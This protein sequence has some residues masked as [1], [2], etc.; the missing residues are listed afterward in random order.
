[1]H[2]T[3]TGKMPV[4]STRYSD[5]CLYCSFFTS[6]SVGNCAARIGVPTPR[7][8]TAF[9]GRSKPVQTIHFRRY[10]Q[11]EGEEHLGVPEEDV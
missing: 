9:I 5:L 6:C 3:G 2:T 1:M 10:S 4:V 7:I 11:T 8:S